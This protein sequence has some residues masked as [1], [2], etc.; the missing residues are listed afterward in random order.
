VKM[1]VRTSMI[2]ASFLSF[3]NPSDSIITVCPQV[4]P[5]RHDARGVRKRG[6]GIP[7]LTARICRIEVG[8]ADGEP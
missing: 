7:Y 2:I 1:V 8:L 5:A 3:P 6:R 4:R